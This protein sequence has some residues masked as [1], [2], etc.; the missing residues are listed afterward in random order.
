MDTGLL[1]MINQVIFHPRGYAMYISLDGE[2]VATGW[3]VM[4]N[5]RE[6]W[7]FVDDDPKTQDN[8]DQKFSAF[9]ELLKTATP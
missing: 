7:A 3:G 8:L 6:R 4:G 2:G 9:R 1:W 5:G